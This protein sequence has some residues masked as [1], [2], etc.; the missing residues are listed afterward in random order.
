[1]TTNLLKNNNKILVKK[2]KLDETRKQLKSEFF[3]LD[4]IIDELINVVSAWYIF[5]YIQEKPVVVNLW[6][7][8]GTGKTSLISRLV[9]LLGFT[10]KYYKFNIMNLTESPFVI[11]SV[12]E[13]I[14]DNLNGEPIIIALDEFQ[15]A[16][17]IN[18]NNEEMEKAGIRT[19][20]E[21]LDTGKFN[22]S[23]SSLNLEELYE[24]IRF[25]NRMLKIGIVV[26]KGKVIKNKE[27][28]IERCGHEEYRNAFFVKKSKDDDSVNFISDG[29]VQH[30]YETAREEFVHPFEIREKLNQLD[31]AGTIRFLEKVLRHG[32]SPRVIDS[33]KSIIFV[34]G[35]LDEAYLMGGN[36]TPDISADEF[37]EQSKKINITHI[38]NALK[39]RFRNEQISRLGN[40]HLIYPAFNNAVFREII[41]KELEKLTNKLKER[42][43]LNV[44]FDDTIRQ[45]IYSE[46]VFPT[47]GARPVLAT[48][49][50]IVGARLGKMA[51]EILLNNFSPDKIVFSYA[52]EHILINYFSK[53]KL[54]YSVKEK[55][56]LNLEKLRQC[57]KDDLQAIT[58]VHESGHAVL[59]AVLLKIIPE[60][61]IS[62]TVDDMVSGFVF[63]KVGWNYIS[64]KELLSRVAVYLGGFIA[65]KIVFGED[66]TTFGS[67]QDIGKATSLLANALKTSGMGKHLARFDVKNIKANYS[68]FDINDEINTEVLEWLD[69]GKKLAEDTLQANK[70]LLLKMSD[71]LSD[72]R[73]IDKEKIKKM[74]LTYGSGIT[75]DQLIENG[76]NLF[77]RRHLKD[78]LKGLVSKKADGKTQNHVFSLNKQGNKGV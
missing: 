30:I 43:K 19:I 1:M 6:G 66:K 11:Q 72:N 48:I 34:M 78:Q 47:Q 70:V 77:Y 40:T 53:R 38:K 55:Q 46:G 2:R 20:W 52:E 32:L 29:V 41:N 23:R 45:L 28:F 16:R 25:Y 3:G 10:D 51:G 60:T 35:N 21:L 76:D 24:S 67:E 8:T 39:A 50:Q 13:D 71:Y 56:M 18:E 33:S 26:S 63:S 69:S 7:L 9:D 64:K 37:Y 22:M 17:T 14:D 44:V 73:V 75:E 59:T 65:E 12:L 31:G 15:H 57:K 4:E 58:A 62:S 68:V 49:Q 42:F 36:Y 74:V 61:V 5:P 54:I 27:L